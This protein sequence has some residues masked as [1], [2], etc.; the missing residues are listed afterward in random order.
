ME[1]I[2][3]ANKLNIESK[4][5]LKKKNQQQLRKVQAFLDIATLCPVF[6]I[7]GIEPEH[8]YVEAS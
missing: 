6:V 7:V 8:Y 5:N 2:S 4:E 1:N 3:M